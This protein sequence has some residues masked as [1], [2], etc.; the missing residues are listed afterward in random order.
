M[1]VRP[2]KL[3]L[4]LFLAWIKSLQVDSCCPSISAASKKYVLTRINPQDRFKRSFVFKPYDLKD[5]TC[6]YADEYNYKIEIYWRKHKTSLQISTMHYRSSFSHAET[7]SSCQR[8]TLLVPHFSKYCS[9]SQNFSQLFIHTAIN[10]PRVN[11]F[12]ICIGTH[13]LTEKLRSIF[14]SRNSQYLLNTFPRFYS[15]RAVKF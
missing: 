11:K 3:H 9:W 2:V 6:R 8:Q 7:R 15:I 1:S 14:L 5:S 10:P 12:E 13:S 4:K